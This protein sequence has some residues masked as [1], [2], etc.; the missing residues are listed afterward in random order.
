MNPVHKSFFVMLFVSSLPPP[1]QAGRV[2]I[3]GKEYPVGH[4]PKAR[5][6]SAKR[7]LSS[8]RP[9]FKSARRPCARL[10]HHE[11]KMN[12]NTPRDYSRAVFL[13]FCHT[14]VCG[15]GH[16]WM[17][18]VKQYRCSWDNSGLLRKLAKTMT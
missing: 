1:I 6:I 15:Y 12:R 8:Q 4:V 18:K 16:S 3:E 14:L 13:S 9:L 17:D 11:R 2:V 10:Q 5:R 7:N